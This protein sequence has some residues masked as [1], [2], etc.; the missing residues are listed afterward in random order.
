MLRLNHYLALSD[1]DREG[2]LKILLDDFLLML[3]N[4]EYQKIKEESE[5]VPSVDLAAILDGCDIKELITLF[6]LLPKE[7]AAEVFVELEPDVQVKLIN[8]FTDKELSSI[9]DE[10]YLDDTVD[11]IEELPATVV[12]RVVASASKEDREE[13][14][15]LL[16]FPKNSVG[17]IMTTE[18]VRL[19]EKMTVGEA[20]SHIRRVAIDSETIYNCYVTDKKRRLIGVVSAKDL[21]ISPPDRYVKDIMEEGVVFAYTTDERESVALKFDTYGFIALPVTDSETRLVGIVTVD[22]AITVLREETEEDF[23]KMAAIIPTEKTYKESSVLTLFLARIPWLLLLMLTATFSGAILNRFE[24]VLPTVFLLFV[25]MLMDTGGNSGGQSSVSVIRALSLG[26][27]RQRDALRVLIKEMLVGLL[28]GITL[29]AVAFLKVYFIDGL[30]LAN[31]S[32]T[33]G[34]AFVVSATLVL[35]VIAA[36]IIGSL[37][38]ILA[39]ALRLDPAVMA[40]PLITTVVDVVALLVYFFISSSFFA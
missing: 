4:R 25:P 40:S 17:A 23:S 3:N 21:L 38:P 33:L 20:L 12:K 18:Y 13:I 9:L 35:T 11:L 5:F 29:G 22:D 8:S 24:R 30:L 6:R 7:R 28:S 2:A 34:V 39:K 37:L 27:I 15:R 31:P 10:L 14:N 26:E 32:V 19:T 1:M 36:K 16:C